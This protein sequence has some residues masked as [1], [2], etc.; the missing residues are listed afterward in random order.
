MIISEHDQAD[1]IL[2]KS[3]VLVL[4]FIFDFDIFFGIEFSRSSHDW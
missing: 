3:L 4:R 2:E 1:R